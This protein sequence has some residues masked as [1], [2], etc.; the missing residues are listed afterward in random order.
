M[1]IIPLPGAEEAMEVVVLC[2]NKNVLYRSWVPVGFPIHEMLSVILCMCQ[3][4][5]M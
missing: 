5:G 3:D 4:D 2:Y 1:Y